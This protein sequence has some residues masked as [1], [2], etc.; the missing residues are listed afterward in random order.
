M[1]LHRTLYNKLCEAQFIFSEESR[2]TSAQQGFELAGPR[3]FWS[4]EADGKMTKSLPP[5][6]GPLERIH[7][8][9]MIY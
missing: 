1:M 4:K 8:I 9:R 6:N 7:V 3:D 5:G 2:A